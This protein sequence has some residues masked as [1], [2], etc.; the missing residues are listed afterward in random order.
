LVP[1]ELTQELVVLPLVPLPPRDAAAA[2][3]TAPPTAVVLPAFKAPPRLAFAE[4]PELLP[5]MLV[6]ALVPT[7][8]P[9]AEPALAALGAPPFAP[10]GFPSDDEHAIVV[11]PRASND[12]DMCT[13]NSITQRSK[14]QNHEATPGRCPSPALAVSI[15]R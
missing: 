13:S 4:V 5:P 1:P 2:L 15:C 14:H 12:F 11:N 9:I 3:L 7:F 8:A 10:A 6:L